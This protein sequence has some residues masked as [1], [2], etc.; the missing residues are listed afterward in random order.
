MRVSAQRVIGHR[1]AAAVEP[2]GIIEISFANN[3]R[4]LRRRV[5]C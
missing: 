4:E 5:I 1:K 3:N 2:F